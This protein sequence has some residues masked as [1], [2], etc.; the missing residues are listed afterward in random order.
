MWSNPKKL[1]VLV[2]ILLFATVGTIYLFSSKAAT[3][4]NLSLEAENGANC[5]ASSV[6]NAGASSGA[7]TKFGA[8]A[9]CAG[10]RA[11][12]AG[13]IAWA[14]SKDGSAFTAAVVKS[15]A[16]A[17]VIT[18]GDHAYVYNQD[19]QYDATK[20]PPGGDPNATCNGYSYAQKYYD[21]WGT[22]QGFDI[23]AIT[24]P[25]IGNHEYLYEPNSTDGGAHSFTCNRT[26]GKTS[27]DPAKPY[28]DYFKNKGVND[29]GIPVSSDT[30]REGYYSFD[31]G[32][33]HFI[34]LNSECAPLASNPNG[35]VPGPS[36]NRC[37]PGSPQYTW[38]ATDLAQHK[39]ASCIAAYFHRPVWYAANDG[40]GAAIAGGKV[41]GMLIPNPQTAEEK[42]FNQDAVEDLSDYTLN[43]A[44][45]LYIPAAAG[46]GANTTMYPMMKL[47]SQY[48]SDVLLVGHAHIY[49]HVKPKS[50]NASNAPVSDPN[51]LTE[52]VVGTGGA[53]MSPLTLNSSQAVAHSTKSTDH[54]VL[55]MLLKKGSMDYQFVGAGTTKAASDEITNR[56]N[57]HGTLTCHAKP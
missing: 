36:G 14:G 21:K 16:P 48:K 15:I 13:D 23:R 1:S 38:L 29:A 24:H 39:S 37:G 43:A 32:D 26:H 57:D 55:S 8:S 6:N 40:G 19:F 10:I 3:N 41:G 50:I 31:Q 27:A 4:G 20:S 46:H 34:A 25:S 56:I 51:G 49:E 42:F 5:P 45:G 18:L 7:Y 54:G 47:L 12:A 30:S 9:G 52:F 17:A 35:A 33:W 22:Y 53:L 11:I 2:L 44:S 28:F